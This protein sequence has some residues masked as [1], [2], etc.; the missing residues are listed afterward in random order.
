MNKK[1]ITISIKV[2]VVGFLIIAI[3]IIL[4][5]LTGI[6]GDFGHDV[7]SKMKEILPFV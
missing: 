1:S 5:V 6:I 7:I 2:V 4:L 3:G